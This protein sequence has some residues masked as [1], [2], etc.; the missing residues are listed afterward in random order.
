MLQVA[1]FLFKSLVSLQKGKPLAPSVQYLDNLKKGSLSIEIKS[2][3][4]KCPYF[5]HQI[6]TNFACVSV[7]NMGLKLSQGIKEGLSE[8]QTWDT[9]AGLTLVDAA[10]AHSIVTIHSFYLKESQS[11]KCPKLKAVLTKMCVLYGL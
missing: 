2:E 9:Y 7:K 4:L 6:L 1:R 11:V 5:V 3:S 10:I 8:K